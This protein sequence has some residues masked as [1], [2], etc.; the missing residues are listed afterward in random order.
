MT[1]GEKELMIMSLLFVVI[2]N[3]EYTK[4]ASGMLIQV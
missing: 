2:Q 1:L 4:F 3:Y